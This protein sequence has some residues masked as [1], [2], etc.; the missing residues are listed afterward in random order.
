MY[1]PAAHDMSPDTTLPFPTVDG[2]DT[3]EDSILAELHGVEF[4]VDGVD[5][6]GGVIE[7]P[8]KKKFLEH[9]E[10]LKGV[11]DVLGRNIFGDLNL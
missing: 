3:G 7:S 8:R 2:E 9:K 11:V 1:T 6:L 10:P 5:A 4:N